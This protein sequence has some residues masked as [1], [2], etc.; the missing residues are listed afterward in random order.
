MMMGPFFVVVISAVLYLPKGRRLV[1]MPDSA[2]LGTLAARRSS[3]TLFF[4]FS[5]VAA[6]FNI[7]CAAVTS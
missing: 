6:G 4:V 7:G 1:F 5:I 2:M 3:E